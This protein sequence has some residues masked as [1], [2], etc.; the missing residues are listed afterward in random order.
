M[1][2]AWPG[3]EPRV[4]PVPARSLAWQGAEGEPGGGTSAFIIVFISNS[5]VTLNFD[6]RGS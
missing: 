6:L 2:L 3:R 5:E 1:K 4:D